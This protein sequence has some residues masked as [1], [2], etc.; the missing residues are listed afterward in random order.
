M[1]DI[2]SFINR[3]SNVKENYKFS[4][5]E[6]VVPRGWRSIHDMYESFNNNY[7]ALI[8]FLIVKNKNELISK[9][10]KE[11]IEE[12]KNIFSF[13]SSIFDSFETNQSTIFLVIPT[14]YAILK[15]LINYEPIFS[16]PYNQTHNKLKIKI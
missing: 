14:Y 10:N 15:F 1:T 3:S 7:E 6:G 4:L 12:I 8:F 16:G 5:R 9:L 13:F 11:K 2:L